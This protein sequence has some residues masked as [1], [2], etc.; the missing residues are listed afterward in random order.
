MMRSY[1]IYLRVSTAEQGRSGLGLAAQQRDIDL[2]LDNYSDVPWEVLGTFTDVLS[3]ADNARPELD[4][5]LIMARQTGAELLVAKLDRLSRNVAFIAMVMGD[6]KVKLRVASMPAADKFQLHI[7]AALAEQERDFISTRTKAAL[8]GGQG[9]GQEARR[10][11]G[12]RPGESQRGQEGRRCGERQPGDDADRADARSGH[13]ARCDC[14][15][16]EPG[17]GRRRRLERH[18]GQAGD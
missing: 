7:Y 11:Q 15:D 17:Q 8:P 10:S 13:V 9:Q 1:V 16:A 4:K 14:H 6:K 12:R 5:A 18:Q 2:F 3:G